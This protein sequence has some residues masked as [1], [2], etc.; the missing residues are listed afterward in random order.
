MCIAADPVTPVMST[1]GSPT[2]LPQIVGPVVQKLSVAVIETGPRLDWLGDMTKVVGPP[3]T[4]R[5]TGETPE[6]VVMTR[7]T[8]GV[9]PEFTVR[10]V[11]PEIVPL[12][13]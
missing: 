1:F 2:V 5:V 7:P 8:P 12:K 10:V 3:E 9:V 4:M 11:P 6:V 13:I